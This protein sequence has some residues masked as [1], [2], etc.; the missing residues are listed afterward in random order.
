MNDVE[1]NEHLKVWDK[2]TEVLWQWDEDD[3]EHAQWLILLRRVR[4]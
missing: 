4:R 3:Q 1:I 2:R